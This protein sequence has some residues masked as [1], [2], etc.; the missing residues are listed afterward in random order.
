[1]AWYHEIAASLAA[2]VGRRRQDREMDEEMRFHLEMETKRHIDAGHAR[3]RRAAVARRPD[4]GGVERHKD[5]T[6]DERGAGRWFDAWSDVRFALRSLGHRPGLTAAATLTLALGIG[7]TSTVF[8]VVKRVL[9]TPLPYDQPESRRRRVERVE[10]LRPDVALVRRVGRMESES[11][12]VRR[13]R[14]VHR[15]RRDHRRRLAGARPIR[16]VQ[17]SVFSILGVRARAWARLHRGRRSSG[18]SARR[19]AE[20]RDW[21]TALRRGSVDRRETDS[22]LRQ[23][24]DDR[25][26][27]AGGLP[28]AARLRG[29]RAHGRVVSA[30]DRRGE[31][32]RGARPVVSE[33][34]CEP[35]LLRGRASRARARR[36][37]TANTQL[38]TL[39]AELEQFGY[40]A[41]VDF[42]AFV[43]P[44]EEQITGRV[45]P[46]LL[47]VFGA[48]V[49]VLLI[50][51]AN[52]A[53][54]LL[55]RGEARRRELAVR[56][57]LGAGDEPSCEIAHH[58]ERGP[59]GVRRRDG[60]R[61]GGASP[62]DCCDLMH[63]RACRA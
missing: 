39:V 58:G 19:G 31:R 60:H 57:A 42:H 16:T 1:M 37:P 36:R 18:W 49:L 17:A 50:A 35:R 14:T 10:G 6:R 13:H 47:V 34:R 33:G 55:V 41:N 59:R 48:V 43:V 40:M 63:R 54:L 45:R 4:F 27:D 32:G 12:R 61:V 2:L 29:R 38:K 25:R 22:D 9:L 24:D 28:D 3:A 23:R 26:R 15:R 51:C 8:G 56:V 21:E 5:D 46:V 7:A 62:F 53:G 30:R 44:I 11:A 52:V 20:P